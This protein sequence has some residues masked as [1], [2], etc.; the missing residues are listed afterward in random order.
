MRISTNVGIGIDRPRSIDEIVG[1]VR[2]AADLG[3]G[4]AWWARGTRPTR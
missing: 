4:G 1:E 2:R 3:L